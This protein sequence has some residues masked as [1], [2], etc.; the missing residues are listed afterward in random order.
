MGRGILPLCVSRRGVGLM[1]A[2]ALAAGCGAS[3][4]Y[5]EPASLPVASHAMRLELTDG[6]ALELRPAYADQDLRV[7]AG[8]VHRCTGPSCS[9]SLEMRVPFDAIVRS[10]S[11]GRDDTLVGPGQHPALVAPPPPSTEASARAAAPPPEPPPGRVAIR[12]GGVVLGVGGVV[13]LGGGIA[14]ARHSRDT[15]D[16]FAFGGGSYGD[17]MALLVGGTIMVVGTIVLVAGLG[18]RGAARRRE[19]RAVGLDLSPRSLQLVVRF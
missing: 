18:K 11:T 12:T 9:A 19:R 17:V 15:S 3:F 5:V 2:C 1:A 16:S 10:G 8:Y 4:R 14:L 13:A 7:V 6:T